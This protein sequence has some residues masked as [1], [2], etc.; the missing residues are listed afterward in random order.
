[1]FI[2]C[3]TVKIPVLL[4]LNKPIK[5]IITKMAITISKNDD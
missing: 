1:M 3:L 5:T 4:P 2:W